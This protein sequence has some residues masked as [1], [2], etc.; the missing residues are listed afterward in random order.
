VTEGPSKTPDPIY[1]WYSWKE[2]YE[3]EL[4][5]MRAEIKKKEKAHNAYLE[6][7]L[8]QNGRLPSL[9]ED[10]YGKGLEMFTNRLVP[11]LQ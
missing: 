6:D 11:A 3:A 7:F 2:D 8:I 5:A 1:E 10:K 9:Q 4:Q